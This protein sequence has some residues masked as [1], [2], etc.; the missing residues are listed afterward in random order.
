MVRLYFVDLLIFAGFQRNFCCHLF[1]RS[2]DL[3]SLSPGNCRIGEAVAVVCPPGEVDALFVQV[4]EGLCHHL[5]CI[6]GQS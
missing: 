6:V 2:L 3:H 5:H 1:Q 4:A